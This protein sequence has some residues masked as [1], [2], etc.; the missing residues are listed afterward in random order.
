MLARATIFDLFSL[1]G[2]DDKMG[3]DEEKEKEAKGNVAAE[4]R[5]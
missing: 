5:Y 3:G 4:Q 2:G 1:A